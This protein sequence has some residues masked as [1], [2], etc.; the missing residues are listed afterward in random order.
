[1][2]YMC[3][4][5]YIQY[6]AFVQQWNQHAT[7]KLSPVNDLV[8]WSRT[9]CSSFLLPPAYHLDPADL[10]LIPAQEILDLI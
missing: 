4:V 9:N 1:M 7:F 6:L 2:Y 10:Q 8:Y 5:V 3:V